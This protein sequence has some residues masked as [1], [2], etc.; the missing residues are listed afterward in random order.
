MVFLK[1]IQTLPIHIAVMP[2]GWALT[3]SLPLGR[4]AVLGCRRLAS[5]RQ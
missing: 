4:S 3:S 1:H 5:Q 2:I